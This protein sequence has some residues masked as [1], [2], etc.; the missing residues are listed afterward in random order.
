VTEREIVSLARHVPPGPAS[1]LDALAS[2]GRPVV[3]VG[4]S[5]GAAFSGGLLLDRTGGSLLGGSGVAATAHRD[6]G[7]HSITHEAL[8]TVGSS[9]TE[10]L[11][12]AATA[13]QDRA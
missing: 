2:A 7:G 12:G 6:D 10:L 5:G 11:A 3:L 4:F 9:L 13:P 8:T 1:W